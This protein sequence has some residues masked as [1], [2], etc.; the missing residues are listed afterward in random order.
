[1]GALEFPNIHPLRGFFKFFPQKTAKLKGRRS[2]PHRPGNFAS[3]VFTGAQQTFWAC[4]VRGKAN[5]CAFFSPPAPL[6]FFTGRPVYGV[7]RPPTFLARV[8]LRPAFGEKPH[9]LD[10][11]AD[12]GPPAADPM[13]AYARRHFARWP[14]AASGA[15]GGAGSLRSAPARSARSA[16]ASVAQP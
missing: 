3:P 10:Y 4:A 11:S 8:R 12:S 5:R 1:M 2:S 14:S 7:Q 6:L 9:S 15:R 13:S 16:F